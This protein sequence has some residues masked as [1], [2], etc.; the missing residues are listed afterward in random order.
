MLHM[1]SHDPENEITCDACG[2]KYA[3]KEKYM[4][5]FRR[6]HTGPHFACDRCDMRFIRK[7][8]LEA[9]KV[10]VKAY[11]KIIKKFSDYKKRIF[12]IF[13]IL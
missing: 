9:H 6:Y 5:H 12:N 3:T 10:R 7:E 8:Q 11:H 4:F 2:K 1:K 13:E